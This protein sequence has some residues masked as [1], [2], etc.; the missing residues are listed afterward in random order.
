MNHSILDLCIIRELSGTD[1]IPYELLLEA[2]P[3]KE[4]V[5]SY[6]K[7]G[8]CSIAVRDLQI[9]GVYVLCVDKE[10]LSAEIVNVSVDAALQGCGLGKKLVLHAIELARSLGA[11]KICVG[12]GN[13]SVSQL[14]FYQKCGF[15]IT[16]IDFDFFV[17][18]Y[19]EKIVENGIWCRDMLKLSMDL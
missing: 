8:H 14:A 12:T 7:S 15:R 13:S 1:S 3:S 9:V 18:N 2:D 5:D 10:D 17:R 11:K 4:L 16:E 6:L 19:S